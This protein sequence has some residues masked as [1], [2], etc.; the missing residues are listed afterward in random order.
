MYK[1][2]YR[3]D[4]SLDNHKERLVAKGYAQKEGID[5]EETFSPTTKWA[6]IHTL[7][8]LAAQNGWKVH[9]MDVKTSLFNGDLKENVFMSH[10]EGFVMK[11]KEQKVCKLVKSLYGLKQAP[12]AWYE[13][14]IEHLLK[15]NFK[16]FDLDDATLF[17]KKVGRFVV[18]VV[19]YVDDLLMTG[20]NESYIASCWGLEIR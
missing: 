5:Y 17:I 11:G 10:P 16:H 4:G 9:Q 7:L 20:N 2:K 8:S 13:K 14:L 18:Y 15:L 1:N 19:V 3:S 12:R 6:T